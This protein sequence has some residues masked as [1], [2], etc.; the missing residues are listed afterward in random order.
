MPSNV[1][2]SDAGDPD[3][4]ILARFRERQK[5]SHGAD[6]EEPWSDVEEWARLAARDL[7]RELG[8]L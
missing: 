3:G 2:G 4:D 5:I 1:T 6:S 8:N 7:L